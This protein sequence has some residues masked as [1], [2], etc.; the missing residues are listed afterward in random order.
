MRPRRDVAALEERRTRAAD[1]LAQGTPVAEVARQV[2][3]SHQ[4]V[5]DSRSAWRRAGRD[6]PPGAARSGQGIGSKAGLC[7]AFLAHSRLR[8]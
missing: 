8:L 4:V 5:S 6:G 7:F 3:V 1:L 2:G